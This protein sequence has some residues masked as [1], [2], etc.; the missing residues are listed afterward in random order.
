MFKKLKDKVPEKPDI[1][2]PKN[3]VDQEMINEIKQIIDDYIPVFIQN[4]TEKMTELVKDKYK[5]VA[6]K[7]RNQEEEKKKKEEETEEE[8]KEEIQKIIDKLEEEIKETL[9][10]LE[11]D[12]ITIETFKELG[13]D[14]LKDSITKTIMYEIGPKLEEVLSVKEVIK[15]KAMEL[16]N[17]AIEKIV[18]ESVSKI[19]EQISGLIEKA[20]RD[21]KETV[22]AELEEIEEEIKEKIALEPVEKVEFIVEKI[23]EERIEEVKE[24]L[25]IDM[26]DKYNE[27]REKVVEELLNKYKKRIEEKL[28][29]NEQAQSKAI[30]LFKKRVEIIVEEVLAK[31][32]EEL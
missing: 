26:V 4:F 14:K 15:E 32:K 17:K 31:K 10:E 1:E 22:Q 23:D 13:L 20:L 27:I 11:T 5:T 28:P 7:K 30:D 2:V 18:D 8:K 16:A 19:E 29:S 9:E 6:K 12:K 24:E 25:V 21:E 3:P